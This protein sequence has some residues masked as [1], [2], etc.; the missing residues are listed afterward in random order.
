MTVVD[1][2][3]N[4]GGNIANFFMRKKIA[5]ESVETTQ[6]NCNWDEGSKSFTGRFEEDELEHSLNRDLKFKDPGDKTY[7]QGAV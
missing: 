1:Y 5:D 2:Y 7:N 3:V 6:V 4:E